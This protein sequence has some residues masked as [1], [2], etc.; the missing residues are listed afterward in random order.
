[1]QAL[2]KLVGL[3][4]NLIPSTKLGLKPNLILV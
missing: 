4:P 3:K 1:M 2:V